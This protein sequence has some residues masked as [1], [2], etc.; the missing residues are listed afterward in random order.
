MCQQSALQVS[1]CGGPNRS[2]GI[3]TKSRDSLQERFPSLQPK[4]HVLHSVSLVRPPFEHLCSS[5][6]QCMHQIQQLNW[7][8][9]VSWYILDVSLDP[10]PPP[11]SLQH[12]F[13]K[14][15]NAPNTQFEIERRDVSNVSHKERQALATFH[16]RSWVVWFQVAV[17]NYHVS[18]HRKRSFCP[19]WRHQNPFRDRILFQNRSSGEFSLVLDS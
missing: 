8:L 19:S 11:S 10:Q 7:T 9:L 15:A 16:Q 4:R 1:N 18:S 2:S 3:A 13:S 14:R 12:R 17:Q 5:R 6:V